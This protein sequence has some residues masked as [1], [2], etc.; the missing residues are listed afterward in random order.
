MIQQRPFHLFEGPHF[1]L[2]MEAAGIGLW[3]WD[4]VQ[5]RMVWSEQCKRVL[6]L[7]ADAAA[8]YELFFSCL[9]PGDRE[10]VERMVQESLARRVAF[11]VTYRVCWPDSAIHWVESRGQ[12]IYDRKGQAIRMVGVVFDIT[13]QA[14]AEEHQRLVERYTL[15]TLEEATQQSEELA[16]QLATKQAFLQALMEQAPSGLLIVGAPSGKLIFYNEEAF[17]LL[18]QALLEGED[19]RNYT[20][21]G[22]I[23]PDGSF[24]RLE[25]YPLTRALVSGAIVRQE[26]MRYRRKDGSVACLAVNA[27]P[28]RGPGGQVIAAICAFDDI[29]A[30]YELEQRKDEFIS[31]AS[32][33]LRAPLTGMMGNLQ[34]AQRR[35][36]RLLEARGVREEEQ[37]ALTE[38]VALRIGRALSQVKI[39]SRMIDDLLDATRIQASKLRLS[40]ELCNLVEIVQQVVANLRA[41]LPFRAI[42]LD[43]APQATVL[44]VVDAVRIGQVV[45]NLLSNALKYSPETEP[46]AIGLCVQERCVRVWVRDDGPGLSQEVQQ[47]IWER[48]YQKPGGG[49]KCVDGGDLGLGLYICQ[50]LIREHGGAIGVQSAPGEGS[51]FWFT[52]PLAGS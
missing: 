43:V 6:G 45:H 35:L 34:M 3:D 15:E 16:R 52:L 47:R 28:I 20:H 8:S 1:Q 39:Q 29:S 4:L 42:D 32:H 25:E 51:T 36:K 5:L 18:G 14:Q 22:A 24:Y 38:D 50:A 40:L 13:T 7:A 33:E 19:Y 30:R 44:V 37:R 9:H 17:R 46:V 2:A 41:V 12:G 21:Y 27:A 26:F 11:H 48:F 10:H 23:H 31:I 49:G